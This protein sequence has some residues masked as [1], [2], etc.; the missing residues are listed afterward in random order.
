[1]IV[2]QTAALF[3]RLLLL[4]LALVAVASPKCLETGQKKKSLE[5]NIK[6]W[7]KHISGDGTKKK[8][9]PFFNLDHFWST[10]AHLFQT[11]NSGQFGKVTFHN[12]SFGS[13]QLYIL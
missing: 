12:R 5:I 13:F 7:N 4:L 8:R 2:Y 3:V 10:A 11:F 9:A 6:I 1:M